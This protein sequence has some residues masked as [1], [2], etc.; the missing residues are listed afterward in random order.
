MTQTPELHVQRNA[1]LQG[2]NLGGWL[3]LE[4]WMTPAVFSGSD[5]IDE[6]TLSQTHEGQAAI[7]RHRDS[8]MTEEDFAWLKQNGI[9]I[10]RLPVGYWLFEAEDGMV[11]Q[12]SHV[13]WAFDMAEAYGISIL[14]DLHAAK[15]SQNGND[16]SGRIG[17]AEWFA[18]VEYRKHTVEVLERMANR[19]GQRRA[20]WGIQLL[21][22]PKWG[23][24]H[25][26]LRT[27]YK[28]ARNIVAPLLPSHVRIVFQDGFT[29]N[30]LNG[31]LGFS[32]RI[33]MDA[34]LY[35]GVKAWT[36]FVSLNTYYASLEKWQAWLIRY[37]SWTQPVIIG[38]WSGSFRQEVFNLFPV[39]KHG[40]LVAEHCRRQIASFAAAEAWFYWNY[41]TE[42]TG[43]WHFRSQV[44]AGIIT[45]EKS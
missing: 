7:R 2:V 34:H 35:H 18:H 19:Y 16:H 25:F 5:A 4:K 36:K 29:P 28:R 17:K 42:K 45:L 13:D 20:L 15:G 10:V 24:C 31:A 3:I 40:E 33:V 26:K 37:L 41:K 39:E 32:R 6:Y 38:E 14:L 12:V 23:L 8:F 30:L 43:V 21:N 1:P 27:F 44:E 22:E 9:A 11:P